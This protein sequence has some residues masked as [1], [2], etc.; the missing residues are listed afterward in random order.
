MISLKRIDITAD[1]I[2]KSNHYI[3]YLSITHHIILFENLLNL[4][5]LFNIA[6]FFNHIDKLVRK[7]HIYYL[8]SKTDSHQL[9]YFLNL[10]STVDIEVH[11][12]I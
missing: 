11:E 10:L 7:Y 12:I 1:L 5:G 9:F 6:D 2:I 4:F 3:L 8:V